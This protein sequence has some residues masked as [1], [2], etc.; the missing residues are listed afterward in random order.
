ML[1]YLKDLFLYEYFSDYNVIVSIFLHNVDKVVH[2]V[3]FCFVSYLYLLITK[4][5][6]S[7]Y[8]LE[9]PKNIKEQKKT[10]PIYNYPKTSVILSHSL[11]SIFCDQKDLLKNK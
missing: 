11:L 9:K 3:D 5:A 6:H 7:K 8:V 10:A 1:L 2:Y 4:L